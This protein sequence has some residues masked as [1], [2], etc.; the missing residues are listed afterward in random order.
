MFLTTDRLL[1]EEWEYVQI[2]MDY[3]EEAKP[4]DF[5]SVFQYDP[6]TR[7]YYDIQY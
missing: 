2:D 1:D 5:Y 7:E 6:K 4:E 3:E